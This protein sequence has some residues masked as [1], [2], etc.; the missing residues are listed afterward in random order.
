MLTERVRSTL[1]RR[2]RNALEYTYYLV[3]SFADIAGKGNPAGVVFHDGTLA[4]GDMRA[5]AGQIDRETAFLHREDDSYRIQFYT[6]EAR[7]PLCGHDTIAAG[8]V[9]AD[10]GEWT[11][12]DSIVLKSDIGDLPIE[13]L[14]KAVWMTQ[15]PPEFGAVA[16]T[17]DIAELLDIPTTSVL[18]DPPPRVVST[19]TPFLFARLAGTDVI[20]SLTPDFDR[21]T[22]YLRDFDPRVMGLYVWTYADDQPDSL[23]GRCF[24]PV[25][26]LPEDPVTGS[27]SGALVC[28][29]SHGDAERRARY[30]VTVKQGS[31]RSRNGFAF[32]T[33]DRDDDGR[34]GRPR[35][36]GNGVITKSGTSAWEPEAV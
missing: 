7:I 25:A 5:I 9:L 36:G 19:G 20:Q 12:G 15:L 23:L 6:S 32:A 1:S 27:A 31:Q 35:V 8:I 4:D 21:M 34:I 2:R 30:Q 10:R 33:V 26:G 13:L 24:A 3:D 14:D 17:A 29:W 28:Y 18:A 16:E 22:R 11:P